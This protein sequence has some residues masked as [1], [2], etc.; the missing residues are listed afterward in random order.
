MSGLYKQ[1]KPRGRARHQLRERRRREDPETIPPPPVDPAEARRE[2]WA[3][4]AFFAAVVGF[5]ALAIRY[6]LM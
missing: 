3:V 4:F 2:G 5:G 1:M 6:G